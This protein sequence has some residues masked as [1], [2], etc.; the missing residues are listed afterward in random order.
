MELEEGTYLSKLII[1]KPGRNF[2]VGLCT[3]WNLPEKYKDFNFD[4]IGT[5]YTREGAT[6]IIRNLL[7][8]PYIKYLIVLD[9]N[10]LGK[11]NVGNQGINYLRD[12]FI[13][14][15][16]PQEYDVEELSEKIIVQFI[17]DVTDTNDE[18]RR[19][20]ILDDYFDH[21]NVDSHIREK[22]I[23]LPP[24]QPTIS[25][26]DNNYLGY[27]IRGNDIF[28]AWYQT[29]DHVKQYG[30]LNNDAMWEYHSIHWNFPVDNINDSIQS[31]QNIITQQDVRQLIGLDMKMLDDYS[32]TMNENLIVTN[33]AYTY[34]NRLDVYKS[35]IK[36][37][38]KENYATRYAFGTTLRYDTIDAQAPCLVY[39]QLLYDHVNK[40]MNLYATFRSHDIF[41]AALMNAYGLSKMLIEYCND[42]NVTA[43]RVEINS[44][45]AHIYQTD[46]KNADDMIKCLNSHMKNILHLDMRCN[47][48][49]THDEKTRKY[50]CE[51]RTHN[52]NLLI[53]TLTGTNIEIYKT[54]LSEKIIIDVEHLRY[55][56]EQL[57]Q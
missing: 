21:A 55:I 35:R 19:L 43:G 30:H 40:L 50:I 4:I 10:V 53:R 47:C 22:K 11:N 49:I 45:S 32:K 34:G 5:L 17:D 25:Y 36:E 18:Y 29:L 20:K 38:L 3:G 31:Y 24:K 44:I 8:N 2:G 41:K 26:H 42:I 51:L 6:I 16:F 15:K 46:I 28:D 27:T 39:I 33:S 7:A 57:F 54:I 1:K 12:I 14:H 52:E 23:Y 48:I 13:N 56:F 9:T 37:N